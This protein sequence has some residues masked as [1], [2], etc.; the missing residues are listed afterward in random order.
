MILVTG[1]TAPT[2]RSIVEQLVAAGHPV[3]ALSRDPETAGL[4]GG[5]EVVAGDLA[6]AESLPPALDGVSAVFF[7]AAVPGVAPAFLAAAQ[8]A[9]A[10]RIV[11]QSSGAVVDG[12]DKQ[13][14]PIGAFYGG[15]EREIVASGLEWTFLRLEMASANSLVWTVDLAEQIKTGDV[16]RAPYGEAAGSPLHEVDLAAVAVAALT[17]EGH[18]GATYRLTG[19]ESLTH[20]E[21]VGRI[22]DA[23]G[24]SLRF[25]EVPVE[26][27]RREMGRR[28]P[29]PIVESLLADWAGHV[30]QPAPVTRTVEAIIGRPARTF[31][32]WATDHVADFR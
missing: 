31:A 19:P 22:G 20:V 12:G 3:R 14:N 9:D 6:L 17:T 29:P 1:A 7:F 16:V 15:I 28:L 32:E 27:A 26:T 4:P 18:T 8:H 13:P 2:G 30:G 11:F 10:P 5:V 25:E 24:R 21:Q 23:I